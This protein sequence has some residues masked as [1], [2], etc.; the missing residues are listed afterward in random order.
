MARATVGEVSCNDVAGEADGAV[1]AAGG[2][3][4]VQDLHQRRLAGA[5]LAEEGVNLAAAD[6]EIDAAER[7]DAG[8]ALGD[9]GCL[10][11]EIR[12][13]GDRPSHGEEGLQANRSPHLER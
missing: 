2:M 10:D 4:A 1:V 9:A 3:D 7:L 11:D 8:K 13:H 6:A 5:V 12:G